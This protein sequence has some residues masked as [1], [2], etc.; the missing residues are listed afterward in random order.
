MN[1]CRKSISYF[2]IRFFDESV[3]NINRAP[4]HSDLA[5]VSQVF[6]FN[7]GNSGD[8]RILAINSDFIS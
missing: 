5:G 1:C 8:Y 4:N 7:S 3:E 2:D 6:G